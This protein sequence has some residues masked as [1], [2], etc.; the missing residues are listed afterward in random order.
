MT[1]TPNPIPVS[2]DRA[3]TEDAL[4][5]VAIQAFLHDPGTPDS[6]VG[7]EVDWCLEPLAAL[8]A[9]ELDELR[10]TVQLLITDPTA[11]RHPFIRYLDRLS[12]PDASADEAHEPGAPDR[13]EP[14]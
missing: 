4:Y 12:Q 6:D 7:V 5:R 14:S 11:N 1:T 8:P 13:S 9:N 10:R 2:I 3:Y